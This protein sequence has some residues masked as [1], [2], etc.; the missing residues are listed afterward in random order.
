MPGRIRDPLGLMVWKNGD[1]MLRSHF[2]TK[3][4]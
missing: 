1:L 4:N 2:S 3:R